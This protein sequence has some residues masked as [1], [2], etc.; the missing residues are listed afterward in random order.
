MSSPPTRT[1]LAPASTMKAPRERATTPKICLTRGSW[2]H[3]TRRPSAPDAPPA[4]RP[5]RPVWLPGPT[6][7]LPGDRL[8]STPA[9]AALGLRPA[10]LGGHL[11]G[12]LH[13]VG[14]EPAVA[15][16]RSRIGLGTLGTAGLGETRGHRIESSGT[17]FSTPRATFAY[18][19]VELDAGL[20]RKFYL[21]PPFSGPRSEG[22]V[23]AYKSSSSAPEHKIP[24]RTR[25]VPL[26]D[27]EEPQE[28]ARPHRVEEAQPDPAE[29]DGPQ[30]DQVIQKLRTPRQEDRRIAPEEE[31]ESSTPVASRCTRAPRRVLMPSAR[32]SCTTTR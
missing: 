4:Q 26:R 15:G 12:H 18:P 20:G 11:F 6:G 10:G 23:T 2:V 19:Q 3:A 8:A 5:A 14:I 21:C 16:S 22:A 7:A 27:H 31:V 29:D 17:P 24:A 9:F 1:A 30:G 25:H 13:L 28:H 32:K